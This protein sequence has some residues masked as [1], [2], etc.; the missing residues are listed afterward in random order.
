MI[1]GTES[2]TK[3]YKKE[4][5]EFAINF[6]PNGPAALDSIPFDIVKGFKELRT[7][8][9]KVYEK[10]LTLIFTKI[11]AE[12]LTCCNQTYIIAEFANFDFSIPSMINELNFMTGYL[13]KDN[14]PEIW[15]SGIIQNW[16]NENP[17][18]FE[19]DEF[20]KPIE[21]IYTP[22]SDINN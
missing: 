1:I 3:D 21:K 20:K 10:Y 11:Y 16:L 22:P 13:D 9:K 12:H 4:I 6:S 2:G 17:K 15:T 18:Y 5:S 14:L 19:M 8:D 7:I